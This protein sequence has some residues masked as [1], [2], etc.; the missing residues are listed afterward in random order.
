[1][2]S[3]FPNASS[4]M[5]DCARIIFL[6]SNPRKKEQQDIIPLKGRI[7]IEIKLLFKSISRGSGRAG[8]TTSKVSTW[9]PSQSVR[10]L[11]HPKEDL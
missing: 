1:M 5:Y 2:L 4:S 11:G 7:F 6:L 3:E 9:Y 10:G 8:I